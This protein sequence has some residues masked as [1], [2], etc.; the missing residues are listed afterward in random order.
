MSPLVICSRVSKK[1]RFPSRDTA[2][3][4]ASNAPLPPAGP[5]VTWLVVPPRTRTRPGTGGPA[6]GTAG[7][8][9][10]RHQGFLGAHVEFDP[11]SDA[12]LN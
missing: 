9:V 1:T 8:R 4:V 11:S 2:A 6:G 5:M 3:N 7:V 12:P 10:R